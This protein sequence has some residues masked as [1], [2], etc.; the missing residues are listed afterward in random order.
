M[1][2]TTCFTLQMTLYS[3]VTRW[4]FGHEVTSLLPIGSLSEIPW[5]K[6]PCRH[7]KQGVWYK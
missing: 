6:C 5:C 1:A 2:L 3:V 4:T 7:G